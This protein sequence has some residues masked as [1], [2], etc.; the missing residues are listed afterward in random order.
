M[1]SFCSAKAPHIF[2]AKILAHLILGALEDLTNHWLMTSFKLTMLWTTGPSFFHF[3]FLT[4]NKYVR[5][6]FA[7]NSTFLRNIYILYWINITKFKAWWNLISAI[8]LML[9][10]MWTHKIKGF[11]VYICSFLAHLSR[12]LTRWAY[13]MGLEPASVR[14]CVRPHF[15]TWISPRTAGRLQPNFI[16]SIIGVGERLH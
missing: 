16:W 4:I 15:Q 9:T 7:T 3:I 2:S 13:R 1:R 11:T 8:E 10:K 12:R 14:L 6:W 5:I